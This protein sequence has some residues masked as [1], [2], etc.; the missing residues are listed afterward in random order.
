[1]TT[2]VMT[3]VTALVRGTA[4]RMEINGV[5]LPRRRIRDW[6]TEADLTHIS[7]EVSFYENCP[8]PD[9]TSRSLLFCSDPKYIELFEYVGADIIELTG[10]HNNDALYVYGV[11]AVP[12]TLD[13]YD[14]V[15]DGL[16]WRR[17]ECGRSQSAPADH[18][19]WQ[20]AGLYR[21]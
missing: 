18:P 5:T 12:F 7:N 11:D 1:M 3:G 21:L 19:Q 15:W 14:A 4:Y 20:S 6:L 17:K 16:F 10:N 13:L 2:L 9:P 8:F